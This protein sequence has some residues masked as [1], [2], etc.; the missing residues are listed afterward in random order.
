MQGKWLLISVVAVGIG[1][2]AGA[3]SMRRRQPAQPAGRNAAAAVIATPEVA[4]NGIIRPQH[5]TSVGSSV[6]GNIEA[7]LANVGDDVFQGQVLAKIGAAALDADRDTASHA[8]ESA[9]DQV[10]KAEAAISSARM[11]ASRANADAQRARGALDR[12]QKTYLRQQTLHASGAT[13]RLVY[14][15]A[16]EEYEAAV[17]ESELLDKAEAAANDVVK[18]AVENLDLAKKALAQKNQELEAA[19]SAMEAAEVR[20]PVD[21]MIVGRKGEVGKPAQEAGEDMF[22]IATDIYALEVTVEPDPKVLKQI[23]PGQQALVV[24]LDLQTP[25]MPGTVKDVKDGKVTVE[26]NSALPAIKPGMRADVRLKLE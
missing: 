1:V 14:E 6:N 4:L 26:F 11:E 12:A 3:L 5:V 13:P 7:F 21:G 8:V 23:H 19:Q 15:K 24:V 18:A 25:G 9:Q 10:A 22:Q 2:G 16:S 20:A 17:K